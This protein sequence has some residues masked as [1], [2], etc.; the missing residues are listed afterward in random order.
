MNESN[1]SQKTFSK[2]ID[3]LSPSEEG[4]ET[5][6]IQDWMKAGRSSRKSRK[7][8]KGAL[9]SKVQHR[10]GMYIRLSP[11][12][13]IREEGS[14]ISHPQRIRYHVK[15]KNLQTPGWGEIVEQYVDKDL[16]GKDINRPEYLRMLA[17]IK[18][19]KIN[20]VIV[21]ELSRLNRNV[22]DFLQF[23]DFLKRHNGKF[24]S[25]KENFDTSTAI[26]EMMVIQSV[27]FAQFE[28]SSIVERIRYGARARAERGL[29]NGS[30]RCLGYDIDQHRRNYLVVNEAER[31]VI[32]LIFQKFLELGT[33]AKLRVWLNDNG[34]RTKSYVS[35]AGKQK[36]GK[37]FTD[38]SL[39]GLLTNKTYLGLR[40]F[41]K[42]NRS[43][44]QEELDPHEQYRV[45][46]AVWPALIE[47]EVFRRVQQRLEKNA[48][49]QRK[50][51]HAY[52][53]SGKVICG[54]CG[55]DLVG[56]SATGRKRVYY[57]YG[58]NRKFTN[59]SDAHAKRCPLER[60][61]AL[62]FE[63]AVLGRLRHLA[64]NRP[65]LVQMAKR[66]QHDSGQ[67]TPNLTRLIEL[68]RSEISETK[69][70][71]SNLAE[72]I[73]SFPKGVPVDGLIEKL[74]ELETKRIDLSSG[75]AALEAE[76]KETNQ[77]VDLNWV[78]DVLQTVTQDFS[79]LATAK[80]RSLVDRIVYRLTLQ[81]NKVHAEYYG[82]ADD[83]IFDFDDEK[84]KK[85]N[86]EVPRSGV[87]PSFD[88]VDANG[89]EPMTPTMPLWCST[90]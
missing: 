54:E 69:E 25:L 7:T 50:H 41:K 60:V 82:Q 11:S 9:Q 62:D 43:A 89:I 68:K 23:W 26:G 64:K 75:L 17:D 52:L 6:A 45:A 20:A 77:V 5:F 84:D 48:R 46:K 35:K 22:K 61:S 67:K 16:S 13:E 39:Y 90:N 4:A 42:E 18:S 28:R 1:N 70:K 44:D 32:K 29:S 58:H 47:P 12:D 49:I 57:Y 27:S 30:Q 65:L 40:E 21:T 78:F 73:A 10:L 85:I 83:D 59:K 88:L 36:G 37:P 86:L 53:L 51:K 66:S 38:A 63:K 87:L 2:P 76:A 79:K 72:R 3:S 15:Y 24:F 8:S 33:I 14:L 34:Y 81:K 56:K 55:A 31:P 80:Q 71:I 19:G 74:Q